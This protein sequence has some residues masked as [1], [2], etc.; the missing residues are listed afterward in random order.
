MSM[1]W[2]L[3]P[4]LAQ[5]G[6]I[7]PSP[8]MD[9]Y[10]DPMNTWADMSFLLPQENWKGPAAPRQLS[11]FCGQMVGGIACPDD[12]T[13]P[14]KAYDAVKEIGRNFANSCTG[15]LWP[16]VTP[17]GNPDGFDFKNFFGGFDAQYF[18]ANIDPSERY[19][20]SLKGSVTSRIKPNESGFSN[21]FLTGD[22]TYNYFNAGCVEATV[23]SGMLCC[24]AITGLPAIQDIEGVR[25]GKWWT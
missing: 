12:P 20:L 7:R 10:V 6:W 23:I 4:T 19:V 24:N 17:P 1:Q 2:W 25:P 18:R 11:Y 13:V 22:W 15:V 9:G 16:S 3:K 5:L 14:A 8:V 21:L